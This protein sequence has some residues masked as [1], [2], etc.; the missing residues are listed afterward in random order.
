MTRGEKNVE[1]YS[2]KYFYTKNNMIFY[3]T[4]RTWKKFDTLPNSIKIKIFNIRGNSSQ[5]SHQPLEYL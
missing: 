2:F 4:M 1:A 3:E 5:N